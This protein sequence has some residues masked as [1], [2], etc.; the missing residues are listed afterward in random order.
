MLF[1]QQAF[2]GPWLTSLNAAQKQAKAKNELIFVDLFADWCGWCH[3][4]E[5]EVFPSEAFQDATANKVLL[6]LNTEDGGEG[7]RLAQNFSVTTLP[8]FLLLTPDLTVAGVIHGYLPAKPFVESMA[9]VEKEY[10][11]F[12]K[13]IAGEPNERDPARRL[14]LAKEFRERYAYT[15]SEKRLL[16]LVQDPK[17]PPDVR[18][19]AY[20]ELALTQVMTRQ[21]DD[22]LKTLGKFA[23]FQNK[24]DLFERS[25]LLAGDVYVQQG[26]YRGAVKEFQAFKAAFPRSQYIPNIDAVLPQLQKRVA[27]GR[28]Q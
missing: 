11:K 28:V 4:M 17:L 16:K 27:A 24:G 21:Y 10:Q 22:A 3:R 7:T 2:A 15:E 13:Q 18:D 19:E 14:E 12:L 1:A 6:R 20:Y 23:T 26:D 25:R 5:Q 8:T 9:D